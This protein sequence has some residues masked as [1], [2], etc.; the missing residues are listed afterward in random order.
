MNNRPR[1]I[2]RAISRS[3]PAALVLIAAQ[4]AAFA[5]E[6]ADA[7]AVKVTLSLADGRKVYRAGEPIRV[8][9]SFTTD[10]G[11]YQLNVTTTKPP[12]AVD[13]VS[14]SPAADVYAWAEHYTGGGGY[15]PDYASIQQL[16]QKPVTV[17]LTLNDWF[18]FD[19]P[20]RYTVRVTTS[21]VSGPAAGTREGASLRLTTN[22]VS[23][24]VTGMSEAEEAAE[25]RRLS[26][27][28]DAAKGW[29]EEARLADE[30]AYL[31]GEA[32]TREKVRRYLAG[33][34]S[35]NYTQSI[36]YG[37]VMARDRAL[38]VRLLEAAIRDPAVS[39][40]HGLLHAA[41]G[42]RMMLEGV[43][44]RAMSHAISPPEHQHPRTAEL[45]RQYVGELLA[46]LPK[47]KGE[48]RRRAAMTALTVSM[49]GGL[50][51]AQPPPGVRDALVAEFDS[52]HPYDQEYLL[53]VY[54]EQ[55]R[56]PSLL[57]AIERM[58]ANRG[59][60]GSYQVK[61]D[62]LRRLTELS[63]ERARP[64]ILAEIRDPSSVVEYEVLT[65]LGDETIPEV[66]EALLG[67]IKTL[68]P[69]RRG[70]DSTLLRHKAMLAARYASPAVYDGLLE[71]Y[72]AWGD[73]W[74]PDA[75]G[76][77][78]GYLARHNETQAL[79]LVEQ[80][81]AQLHPGQDSSLLLELTRSSCPGAVRELLR[82]RLEGDD[83]SAVG[84]A[85]YVMSQHGARA[86]EEL[87]ESRLARWRKEWGGRAAELDAEG[88][89]LQRMAEIN[90][91]ESLLRSKVWK[92]P[93]EKAARLV[94]G[95]VTEDCRRRYGPK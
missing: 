80:A 87:I 63:A 22:E 60:A 43:P 33:G 37:L 18:R 46:T 47:R 81:L 39:V 53:R 40:T 41:A 68:A 31:A 11:G 94:R 76:A 75:R 34:R 4:A 6:A 73:R 30:L 50:N 93:E 64:H 56:D 72:R 3:L 57:P 59:E 49:G 52:F 92:L 71:T 13:A 5:Q 2:F 25:V 58:L 12:N 15:H 8:V 36:Y 69:Q 16:S 95:C 28:L 27:L 44:R 14:L 7:A 65:A 17:G 42:L 86:D 21:R 29:E 78:L 79:P 19:A 45:L 23:F 74:Q 90:L 10:R 77:V 26:A 85:A 61:T 82:R 70:F 38:A 24:E 67:Q 91:L 89:A 54:W 1:R 88:A 35:G 32:A 62:A 9:M 51:D 83:P 55:L 84:A 48:S 20:G 66:D